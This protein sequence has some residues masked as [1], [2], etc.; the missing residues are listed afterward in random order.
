MIHT[1]AFATTSAGA[2]ADL[3]LPGI[4]DPIFSRSVASNFQIPTQ[5]HLF[6]LYGGAVTA[7]RF[8]LHNGSML[9]KGLPMIVPWNTTLLPPNDP[10]FMDLRDK[11]LI[12]KGGEDFRIDYST[13]GAAENVYTCAWISDVTPNLNINQPDCRWLRFTATITAVALGWSN[14][15]NIVF[16]D[17][18]DSGSYNV[19]GLQVQGAN[20]VLA[21]LLFANQQYRPA[22]L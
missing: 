18:L 22:C 15:T 12:L 8:R 3:L 14:F 11:P 9:N 21:R 10:N 16:D 5:H 1:L 20:V 2:S 19:Y 7:L 6:G 13:S 17:V 4:A